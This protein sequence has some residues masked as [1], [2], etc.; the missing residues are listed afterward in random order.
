[1]KSEVD[2]RF[3]KLPCKR[4]W[5]TAQ[6]PPEKSSCYWS[7]PDI[8]ILHQGCSTVLVLPEEGLLDAPVL[9]APL[10]AWW[11]HSTLACTGEPSTSLSSACVEE[12]EDLPQPAGN[13]LPS[14]AQDTVSLLL[15]WRYTAGTWSACCLP[16]PQG[17]SH[18]SCFP[19]VNPSMYKRLGLL[20]PRC[21]TILR[22]IQWQDNSF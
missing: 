22:G 2:Q 11:T 12:K 21:R 9:Q 3:V 15:P 5:S 8:D 18:Q 13:A 14:A 6:S 1:M 4:S 17:P 19:V 20:F 10:A 7:N 16:E